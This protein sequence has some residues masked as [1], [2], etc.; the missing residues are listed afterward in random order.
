MLIQ[1]LNRFIFKVLG[2]VPLRIVLIVPFVLLIFGAVGLVGYVS[3]RNGQQAVNDVA[4][5]LRSEIAA[6]VQ[7]YI[8]PY[9]EKPHLVNQI[10][11]SAIRLGQLNLEDQNSIEH[12][13][14][15]QLQLFDSVTASGFATQE[16]EAT[17]VFRQQDGI[18]VR[19][20]DRSSHTA[21]SY[22]ADNQGDRAKLVRKFPNYDPR[23][24]VWYKIAVEQGK[25]T[26]S[27]ITIWQL[28]PIKISL[29]ASLP[30]YDEKRNLIG[31]LSSAFSFDDV[32]KFLEKLK[33][34]QSGKAFIVERSGLIVATS[35][36]EEPYV[37]SADGEAVTRIKATDSNVPLI[38]ST[39][40][41][42]TARFGNLKEISS[43]QQL[44]FFIKGKRQF[45]QVTPLLDKYGLDWLIM[46]VVP[47]ADF[48]E[49]INGNTQITILLCM[50]ALAVATAI[51]IM[52]ARWVTQPILRLNSVATLLSKGE[53]EH[54]VE[55]ERSD[56][57]GN[58]AHAFNQMA[59]QLQASFTA[60]EKTNQELERRVE[61][62]TAALRD[63]EEKFASAFRS[64]PNP[65]A[66]SLVGDGRYIE[67]NDA[68]C[69][70]S[71]Y[72]R[73]EVIG[74]TATELNLWVKQADR[75]QLFQ[76]LRTDGAI[77]DH[78]FNFH[79]K[80]G[81]VKTVLLSTEIINL[82]GQECL[83]AVCNDISDVCNELH[84]RKQAE[85]SLQQAKEAAE[86]AKEKADAANQA[87]S[88]FLA[89]MSHELRTPL[90]AILGFSQLMTRSSKLNFEQQENLGII[91]R[92]GKHLLALI[93]QVLDLAKIEAG[94][95]T[96]N[97]QDFDLY[98]LLDDLEDMFRLRATRHLQLRFDRSPNV[99]QYV[100]TDEVKL[101]QVLI[102]LLNNAIKF[103]Q[104]GSVTL[105]V[106]VVRC[107]LSAVRNNGQRTIHFEVEDT[108]VGIAPNELDSLF[109]AFVQTK[110]GKV[111]EGTG[112][113]LAITRQF[114]NLMGGKIAV[115]SEVERGSIFQF[116]I[117]ITLV[118][119]AGVETKQPPQRVI[120]L[121]ANQPCYR[122]LIVDDRWENR[123]LLVKLLHPLGFQLREAGDGLEALEIWESWQPHLIW[124]DMR[125][126]VMDGYEATQQ[127]KG[128]TKG[129]ATAVIAM[130]A[131]ILEEEKTVVLSTG[132]N[133]FVRK[134]FQEA[135]IFDTMNKHLGV[136]YVYGEP[137]GMAVPTQKEI[138]ED[139]TPALTAL[140][141]VLLIDLEQAAIC[142]DMDKINSVINDIR[143]CNVALAEKLA[144]LAADFKYDHILAFIQAASDEKDLH[145]SRK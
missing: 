70:L 41:Y 113:G 15:Q 108:G 53:L 89:N 40:Q 61:E 59:T 6:R 138:Q 143:T 68:F 111:Q 2:R 102:N 77:R 83:L 33:I 84:L 73:A 123:Q 119:V 22:L 71:G 35:T 131:S 121:E 17:G 47:E 37:T 78:E 60:L 49:Q 27:P 8:L 133:D 34:S 31:V 18:Q 116:D 115:S 72:A 139:L 88:E 30:F 23:S 110:T 74:H 128:T 39:A 141:N 25:A 145:P 126:P 80:F 48:M 90:N 11:A 66:I 120:A 50:V 106:S 134:P 87:K 36:K 45:L 51:G 91:T 136:R 85:A 97:E 7:Q 94:R 101:R 16:G 63:S 144:M 98:C 69:R 55:I 1:S 79:T 137:T 99:P 12:Y 64:T 124:M 42:L 13:F 118:D 9:L 82:S 44:D 65:I 62:R 92:S 81:E 95:T 129:Q 3:L 28:R 132:C 127:I 14:W 122:I 76:M 58:L 107:Q 43:S 32:S 109:E 56:E 100:R 10:N 117:L 20:L 75:T 24:S 142:V 54:T 125:M 21:S 86:V 52:T 93:N 46:V 96:L 104:S 140:P 29:S 19:V 57:L 38:R 26:W 5:Q 135:D 103:T 114:V 130:T 105:R 67:V 112:L 4:S